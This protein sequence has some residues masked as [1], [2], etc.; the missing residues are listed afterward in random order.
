M[1]IDLPL[2][3]DDLLDLICGDI[4]QDEADLEAVILAK[5]QERKLKR[6]VVGE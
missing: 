3:G 1:E 6:E 4:P 5:V 2:T